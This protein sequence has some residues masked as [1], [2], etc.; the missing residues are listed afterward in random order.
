[1][2]NR[3]LLID[4]HTGTHVD[5]PFHFDPRG[6]TVEKVPLEKFFGV[7]KFLDVSTRRSAEAITRQMLERAVT[8]QG[9]EINKG[10]IVLVRTSKLHWGSKPFFNQKSLDESAAKFLV[11]CK[12]KAVGID[13]SSID[14]KEDMA[15]PVHT[16]FCSSGVLIFEN[17]IRLDKIRQNSFEFIALPIK[18]RGATGSPVRAVALFR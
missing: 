3:I 16:L 5:A 13:L 4:E 9:V 18:L 1:M 11:E 12:V 14:S 6:P 17:L 2:A 15:K 10:D 8:E 7:A